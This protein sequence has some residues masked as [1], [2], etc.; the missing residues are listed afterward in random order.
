MTNNNEL[1]ELAVQVFE[2]RKQN[3]FPKRLSDEIQNQAARLCQS[4]VTAYAIG[5]A[6]NVP[7]VTIT[8]WTRKLLNQDKN[9][10]INTNPFSE[11]KL[12]SESKPKLEIKLSAVI[13]GCRVDLIGDDYSLLQRLLKK[14]NL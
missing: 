3:G 5:K 8:D 9:K 10:D 4:G 6:I 11:V 12:I 1:M 2:F 14:I 13:K 7:G